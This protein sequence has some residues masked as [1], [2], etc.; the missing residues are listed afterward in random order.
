MSPERASPLSTPL[1]CLVKPPATSKTH[2]CSRF[3]CHVT[4]YNMHPTLIPLSTPPI[5][6]LAPSSYLSGATSHMSWLA[7]P[8]FRISS[9]P[10][11]FPV[12]RHT[13][14]PSRFAF[15]H[16]HP[17]SGATSHAN[18]LAFP[19]ASYFGT[20]THFPVPRHTGAG[21]HT[22]PFLFN[23]PHHFRHLPLARVRCP[24]RRFGT[25]HFVLTLTHFWAPHYLRA[26]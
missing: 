18:P 17:F 2:R 25:G 6:L 20:P 21:S 15:R 12:P 1:L 9:T 14:A 8:P 23:I 5:P 11:H 22:L 4:A 3:R 26:S 10:I 19:A 24:S 13:R 7:S 16:P